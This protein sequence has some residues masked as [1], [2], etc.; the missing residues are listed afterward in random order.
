M[1]KKISELCDLL[2]LDII[3]E[4]IFPKFLKSTYLVVMAKIFS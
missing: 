2:F 4:L 1:V 3:S